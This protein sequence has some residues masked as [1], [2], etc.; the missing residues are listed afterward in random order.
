MRIISK[1]SISGSG[2][3][4]ESLEL[5]DT[6]PFSSLHRVITYQFSGPGAAIGQLYVSVCLL[7]INFTTT[8]LFLHN[9]IPRL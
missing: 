7:D 2:R 5:L 1:R 3:I 6:D 8:R 9:I 4:V